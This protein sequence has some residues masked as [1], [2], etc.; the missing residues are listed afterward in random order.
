LAIQAPA[1][2]YGK[3]TREILVE[4]G[5]C[6]DEFKALFEEGVVSES[7][8]EQYIPDQES[9]AASIMYPSLKLSTIN[10]RTFRV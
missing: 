5:Y 6:N 3:D 10:W 7:Y 8:S 1:V 9:T 4:L 2:K